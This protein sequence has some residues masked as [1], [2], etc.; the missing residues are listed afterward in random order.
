MYY[1]ILNE[2][3]LFPDSDASV[4]LPRED[5]LVS[6]LLLPQDVHGYRPHEG[7]FRD[8]RPYGGMFNGVSAPGSPYHHLY[9]Q[10][11]V[12]AFPFALPKLSQET[13]S[14]F[15]DLA[16]GGILHHK[17]CLQSDDYGR[18][19]GYPAYTT[20]DVPRHEDVKKENPSQGTRKHSD[21]GGDGGHKGLM[22]SPQSPLKSDCQPNSPTE[23]SSSKNAHG[24]QAT[25]D[26]KARNWKKYKFIVL[27]QSSREEE[28]GALE[29]EVRSPQRPALPTFHPEPEN[30]DNAANKMTEH[31]DEFSPPQTSRLNNII[32]R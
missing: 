14:A 30:Q 8:G 19:A 24:P 21:G 3:L 7:A 4:K 27:N 10:F 11:P 1:N 20:R 23:S 28:G 9:S 2:G 16:T 13:K 18:G 5:F 22:G 25:S 17:H 26:P 29:P 6:P 12:Q 31:G 15:P 32:N